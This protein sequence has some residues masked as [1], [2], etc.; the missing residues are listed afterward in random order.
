MLSP[1]SHVHS[2]GSF[3]KT[4]RVE[5]V[6]FSPS[7]RALAIVATKGIVLLVAVDVHSRPIRIS[8]PTELHSTSLS[9]PH[10]IDFLSEDVIVVANRAG[11]VTFYRIP[12]VN[13]GEERTTVAPVYSM[14][15]IW[16]GRK[17]TKRKLR[18]RDISCGPGS[19][20]VHRK[21]L[22]VCCNNSNTVTTHT[23]EMR[24]GAIDTQ[25]GSIV[26]Q[27]GL[28]I[29]DGVA[30]SRDGRW[31]AVSDHDHNRVVVYRRSDH[32]QSCVLRDVD[33]RYPHG[34]C[35]DRAGR[36]LYVADAGT[37]HVHVFATSAEWDE[38]MNSSA[39]KL[40]AVEPDAFHRTHEGL[41][42]E[43]RALEGG[44]KGIDVDPTGRIVAT[45]CRHQILRFFEIRPMRPTIAKRSDLCQSRRSAP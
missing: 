14:D 6:K 2:N 19:V 12:A 44:I 7:G 38:P 30:L 43:Y 36:R 8:Q 23:Y 13:E 33:L 16:F 5:D 37:R 27:D 34:L 24:Q 10:G 29:P 39:F 3:D 41:A 1:V 18:I 21:E 40:L 31:M 4:V 28:E 32:T 45:T 11:C 9:S 35:F 20:R 42:A 17:G 22:F 26:A 15:S 25:E